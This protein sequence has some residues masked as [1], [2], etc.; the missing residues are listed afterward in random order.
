ME[1]KFFKTS[2]HALKAAEAGKPIE[3]WLSTYGEPPD[4]Y[5][6]IVT[7]TAFLRTLKEKGSRRPWLKGHETIQLGWMDL[8][9]VPTKGLKATLVPFDG[10]QEVAEELIRIKNGALALSIGYFVEPGGSYMKDGIRYLTDLS[11][12]EG[13]TVIFP[14]N[15]NAILTTRSAEQTRD[16]IESAFV[17]Q[18]ISLELD[19][20]LRQ[21]KREKV[22]AD[23]KSSLALAE[24]RLRSLEHQIK[25][26]R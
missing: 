26:G 1:T 9:H 19:S 6:D 22:A 5:G 25:E 16:D 8:V 2:R 17:L 12:M 4:S 21:A 24:R 10:I 3:G 13:S 14:A 7:E 23:L 15:E 11:L 20:L 18:L